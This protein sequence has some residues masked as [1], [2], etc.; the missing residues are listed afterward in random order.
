[1]FFKPYVPN[2]ENEVDQAE[3]LEVYTRWVR[4]EKLSVENHRYLQVLEESS[5]W[6]ELKG[7][8]EFACHKYEFDTH[9]VFAPSI[10]AR[11][12]V[13]QK[14]MDRISSPSKF[15][16]F[17]KRGLAS[18]AQVGAETDPIFSP[19][20]AQKTVSKKV[21]TFIERE[22]SRLKK[23]LFILF[24]SLI[25]EKLSK[26][27]ALKIA[28]AHL[29]SCGSECMGVWFADC[30]WEVNEDSIEEEL[31]LSDEGTPFSPFFTKELIAENFLTSSDYNENC[32]FVHVSQTG[33]DMLSG[34]SRV[35]GICK[36]TGKIVFDRIIS[37]N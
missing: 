37:A 5:D 27:H 30:S 11:R 15:L 13:R 32:W 4:D 31:V 29:A 28:Q 18:P 21:L 22:F 20:I 23:K 17:L 14:L 7:I 1:M 6:D 19:A 12:R 34:V 9:E 33:M 8:V 24:Y 26:D 3:I 35:V 25:T 16:G 36:S 2:P 10:D